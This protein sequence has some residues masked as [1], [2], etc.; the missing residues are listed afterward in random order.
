M[1]GPLRWKWTHFNCWPKKV[2]ELVAAINS[3]RSNLTFHQLLF[4]LLESSLCLSC[5]P[6][7]KG[8]ISSFTMKVSVLSTALLS[9]AAARAEGV[10]EDAASSVSSAVESASVAVSKPTFTVS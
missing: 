6:K 2:P 4:L 7:Q 8:S 1:H 3:P 5:S 10:V 9:A